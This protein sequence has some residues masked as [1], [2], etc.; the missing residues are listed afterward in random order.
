MRELPSADSMQF[1]FPYRNSISHII[2]PGKVYPAFSKWLPQNNY[3]VKKDK[4]VVVEVYSM[5]TI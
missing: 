5:D 1:D 4:V 3:G 2:G